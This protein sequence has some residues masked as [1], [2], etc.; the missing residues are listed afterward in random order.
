MPPDVSLSGRGG[1]LCGV[2]RLIRFRATISAP[3]LTLLGWYVAAGPNAPPVAV[4]SFSL[5][6]AF[7]L[8]AYAQ[9]FNDIVDR[10]LDA[11]SKPDRPIPAGLISVRGAWTLAVLLALV[12][13]AAAIAVGPVTVV[14]CLVCLVLATVYS[15]WGKP[16]V[17]VGHLIVAGVSAAML[18]YG[19]VSRQ[20]LS[21]PLWVGTAT[22][23]LYIL[24]NELFK[25]VSD[26][27]GDRAFGLATVAT[28]CGKTAAGLLIRVACLGLLAVYTVAGLLSLVE[29]SFVTA[30]LLGVVLPT[31]VGAMRL[32]RHADA[33]VFDVSHRLWRVA[34]GPGLVT[35]A[36][37]R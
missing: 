1:R 12:A 35:V 7:A 37:L 33:R 2:A 30:G 17:M 26:A 23:F 19:T 29:P 28:R 22:V 20:E 24:G 32:H 36:L 34:W 18:G 3:L 31:G 4:V 21:P 8:M 10:D 11:I 6:S 16:I 25:V 14:V 9:V 13:P 27:E 5:L 15:L